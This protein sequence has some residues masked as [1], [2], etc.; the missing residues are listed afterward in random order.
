MR[1]ANFIVHDMEIILKESE[2]FADAISGNRS[3]WSR[4]EFTTA[5]G[6][7]RRTAR[8]PSRER[9]SSIAQSLSLVLSGTSLAGKYQF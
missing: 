5:P 4:A 7:A 3:A 2:T 1:L 8:H 6:P 9:L